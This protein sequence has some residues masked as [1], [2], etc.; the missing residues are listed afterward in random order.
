MSRSLGFQVLLALCRFIF[1]LPAGRLVRC[2]DNQLIIVKSGDHFLSEIGAWASAASGTK[3]LLLPPGLTS[4]RNAKFVPG[5]IVVNNGTLYVNGSGE[6]RT[7]VLDLA[8]LRP[9]E[10]SEMFHRRTVAKVYTTGCCKAISKPS[11]HASS[12][13]AFPAALLA[14][15]GESKLF[16]TNVTIINR[17]VLPESPSR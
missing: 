10:A 17:F 2:D 1:F 4:I 7:S 8:M 12:L 11:L 3:V 9:G 14:L 6:G 15:S 5:S 16:L 13:L